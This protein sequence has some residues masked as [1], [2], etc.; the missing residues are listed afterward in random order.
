MRSPPCVTRLD[1]PRDQ[2]RKATLDRKRFFF[3]SAVAAVGSPVERP[4]T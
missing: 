3:F 2:L 1:M 4:L